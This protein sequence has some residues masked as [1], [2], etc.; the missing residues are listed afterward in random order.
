[1]FLK[2]NQLRFYLIS[3]QKL[4][5]RDYRKKPTITLK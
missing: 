2:N 3:V 1:M 5:L 4:I